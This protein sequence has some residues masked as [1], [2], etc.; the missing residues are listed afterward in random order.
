[1]RL[2]SEVFALERLTIAACGM[3]DDGC[4]ELSRCALGSA[5]FGALRLLNLA[6]NRIRDR[7]AAA[8]A[9]ALASAMSALQELTLSLNRIG[10]VGMHA[11]ADEM[12][13]GSLPAL[14]TLRLDSNALGERSMRSLGGC[15]APPAAAAIPC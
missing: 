12:R 8:L 2:P 10:D 1:M 6:D 9:A 5:T 14:A 4:M 7:G 3:G 13:Q 15:S 11:F